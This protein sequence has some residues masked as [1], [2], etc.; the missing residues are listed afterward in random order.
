MKNEKEVDNIINKEILVCFQIMQ[1]QQIREA[2]QFDEK[3]AV[4]ENKEKIDIDDFIWENKKFFETKGIEMFE[5][6]YSIITEDK[7]QFKNSVKE[8]GNKNILRLFQKSFCSV[9]FSLNNFEKYKVCNSYWTIFQYDNLEL[10]ERFWELGQTF[11][12]KRDS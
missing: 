8:I 2:L 3:T 9:F 10:R 5:F 6:L 7:K 12:S 4:N 1:E 11:F